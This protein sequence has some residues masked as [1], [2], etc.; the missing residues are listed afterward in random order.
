[1][2]SRIWSAWIAAVLIAC[3]VPARAQSLGQFT[4]AQTLALNGHAF[5]AYLHAS[6][7]VVGFVTQLRL[8]FYPG[9]DFGFQGGLDRLDFPGDNRTILRLGTDF[10]VAG[11]KA[12]SALPVDLAFG[13]GLG[14]DTGD[15]ISVLTLGPTVIASRT[16]PAGG[17]GTITPYGALGIS[18]SKLMGK[19]SGGNVELNRKM[20]AEIAISDPVAF[21]AIVSA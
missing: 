18:Y 10:K 12:G 1:M 7:N 9:V 8:S 21:Q 20:L 2:Q 6:S 16:F 5:G 14:V 4:G 11:M 17:R 3:A 15:N 19:L 13:G